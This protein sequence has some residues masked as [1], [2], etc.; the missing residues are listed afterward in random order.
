MNEPQTSPPP[1]RVERREGGVVEITLAREESANAIDLAMARSLADAARGLEIDGGAGAVILSGAGSR[2][3]AGGD[4][5][6]F[7]SSGDDL[8][9]ALR[10]LTMYLHAALGSFARMQAPLVTAVNGAAAG[11]G[12]ALA[13]AGDICIAA[14]SATFRSAYTAIGLSPDA[15]ST[16]FLPRLVGTRRAQELVLTNRVLGAELALDWGLVT[17]VVDDGALL[18]RARAVAGELS[19]LPTAALGA[20]KRLLLESSSSEL[21]EQ[22]DREARSV[23]ALAAPLAT[24]DALRAFASRSRS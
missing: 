14:R 6:S 13:V 15:G 23:S 16:W 8:P 7:V 17:E 18:D 11:A 22:L 24:R 19:K 12:L 4:V 2:F 1:L 20:T 3:C 9:K 10:E 5:R 21:V